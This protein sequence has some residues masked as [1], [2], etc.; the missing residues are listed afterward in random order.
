MICA[1]VSNRTRPFLKR[2][3]GG[4][5]PMLVNFLQDE[6]L[7]TISKKKSGRRITMV[8]RHK[9]M[10]AKSMLP[11][12]AVM[13][14]L[15]G[16]TLTGAKLNSAPEPENRVHDGMPEVSQDKDNLA[17]AVEGT[18]LAEENGITVTSQPTEKKGLLHEVTV[19]VKDG[20]SRLFIWDVIDNNSRPALI[21]EEDINGDGTK[22][23]ILRLS[24]GT[25]TGISMSDIHVLKPDTLEEL[26]VEDPAEAL[27]KSLKSSVTHRNNHTYVSAELN[28]KHLSRVYDYTDGSW[29]TEVGFGANVYYE[30][31]DGRI[32]VRLAGA[33]SMTE[34][35]LEVFAFYNKEL[36]LDSEEMYYSSFMSPLLSE[37]EIKSMMKDWHVPASGWTFGKDGGQYTA[38]FEGPLNGGGQGMS[39]KINPK[40]GT[41]HDATSGSPLKSLAN[42]EAIDLSEIYNGSKYK[43]ELYK[44]LRPILDTEG[45]EPA[46]KDWISGF[47]GD[48]YLFGEVRKE[49][50]E[51][52]I[53]A[54][55][56]TG[57]WEEISD[58]YK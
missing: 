29:G 55:V 41:I 42:R 36:E 56:F 27:N 31:E 32:R 57:Q 50:R 21:D 19:A 14:V 48:G 7:Y 3:Y 44:L 20:P 4:N 22:E 46:R 26:A 1:A 11:G 37:E 28:G 51:F 38:D 40:T 10:T 43:E 23:I 8:T 15:S 13:M 53:K 52:T 2:I 47:L 58:P 30:L 16:C 25:G 39:Y 34:F 49:G 6:K 17:A 12:L 35:P 33:A 24:T 9:K 54:D 18:L 5:A 45:F